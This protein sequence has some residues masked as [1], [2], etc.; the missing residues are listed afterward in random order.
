MHRRYGDTSISIATPHMRGNELLSFLRSRKLSILHRMML[1]WYAVVLWSFE[2]LYMRAT[3]FLCLNT[4]A[5]LW[6]MMATIRYGMLFENTCE[7]TT[8]E[9]YDIIDKCTCLLPWVLLHTCTMHAAYYDLHVYAPTTC[10]QQK[11]SKGRYGYP[12]GYRINS[13]WSALVLSI[14]CSVPTSFL[15]TVFPC[16]PGWGGEMCCRARTALC[17][18]F[19]KRD[20]HRIWFC[21]LRMHGR[22]RFKSHLWALKSLL[23]LA[24]YLYLNKSG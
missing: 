21:M 23:L 17:K 7:L 10:L 5:T 3:L 19:L 11:R 16:H 1:L 8:A 2:S 20:L 15:L 18:M 12:S 9:G 6:L 4:V 14:V 13:W 24:H 22:V